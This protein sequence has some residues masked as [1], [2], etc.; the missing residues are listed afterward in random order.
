M[1]D[2]SEDDE[3]D[4][5]L[6]KMPRIVTPAYAAYEAY[7]K[8]TQ[9][10]RAGGKRSEADIKAEHRARQIEDALLFGVPVE[11]VENVRAQ[12]FNRH[13]EEREQELQ[14]E[15]NDD[16]SLWAETESSIAGDSALAPFT[17]EVDVQIDKR[18][19]KFKPGTFDV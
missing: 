8:R 10:Q 7:K 6:L 17:E 11:E 3:M 13:S 2:A 14:K 12:Y 18:T 1:C 15:A 9:Q 16:A 5:G 19:G 4:M